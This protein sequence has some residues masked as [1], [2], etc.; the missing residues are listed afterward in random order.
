V[1]EGEEKEL[2]AFLQ[3]IAESELSGFI[4]QRRDEWS[5]AKGDL[6]G[7]VIGR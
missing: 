3:G 1:A 6:R 2:N 5:A 4:A 7:F